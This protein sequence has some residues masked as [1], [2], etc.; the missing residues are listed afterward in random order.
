M[1]QWKNRLLHW[2]ATFPVC[3]Y[4][5]S[6]TLHNKMQNTPVENEWEC[7]LAIGAKNVLECSVG[8]AFE[9]LRQWKSNIGPDWLFGFMAYD[10]KNELEVLNSNHW[11]GVKM[12]DLAFFQPEILISIRHN[13]IDIQVLEGDPEAI[14]QSV[15]HFTLPVDND[16]WP[17]AKLGPRMPKTQYIA[18]VEAIREHIVAGDLYEMNLCQEFYSEQVTINPVAVF[19]RLNKLAHSPFT[20]FLRW[21]DRYLLSASPERFLKKSGQKMIS[22]PIKSNRKRGKTVEEDLSI[23]Q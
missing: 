7:L 19:E 12:P 14:W 20:A 10:L 13:N 1:V 6:N 8:S 9:D 4:L 11:D 17:S 16:K 22:Q 21:H 3:V 18:T 23:R 2:A 15:Q 5:D